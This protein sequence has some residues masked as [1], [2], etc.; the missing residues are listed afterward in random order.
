MRHQYTRNCFYDMKEFTVRP[1]MDNVRVQFGA[2]NAVNQLQ[3]TPLFHKILNPL[4]L[5]QTNP[6]PKNKTRYRGF[7]KLNDTQTK[8]LLHTYLK[9]IDENNPNIT[10]VKGP[11]GTGKSCVITNLALQSLYGEEVRVLD[12]KILICA[13]SNTAVDVI[14]R[15][16]HNISLRMREEIRFRIIRFGLMD[17]IHPSV[18]PIALPKLVEKDQLKKIQSM[19][20]NVQLEDRENLKLHVSSGIIKSSCNTNQTPFQMLQ[21][22]AEIVEMCKRNIKG[23]VDEDNLKEKQRQLKSIKYI[24]NQSIRPEDEESLYRWYLSNAHVVCATLSSCVKL[25]KYVG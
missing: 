4:D 5:L 22:E 19:N 20:K 18:M 2:I 13:Q 6:S 12:K 23:T 24:L 3:A 17:R 8:I 14:A 7:D 15:N 10:L 9:I 1:V 21:L 16:L 11:P 25:S